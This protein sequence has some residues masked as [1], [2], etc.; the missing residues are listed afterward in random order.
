MRQRLESKLEQAAAG[1]SNLPAIAAVVGFR[2]RAILI[3]EL[4]EPR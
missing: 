4:V 1:S 3:A 2:E